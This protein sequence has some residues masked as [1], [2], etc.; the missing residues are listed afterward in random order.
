MYIKSEIF[1][2]ENKREMFHFSRFRLKE[3]NYIMLAT[4]EHFL[5]AISFCMLKEMIKYLEYH[6]LRK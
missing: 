6:M 4:Q 1:I 5:N 3:K 2:I